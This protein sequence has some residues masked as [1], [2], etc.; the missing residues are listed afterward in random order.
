MKTPVFY[1]KLKNMETYNPQEIEPKWQ[2]YWEENGF[3]KAEDFS[4]PR[5]Q[6]GRKPK[7]YLLLEFP[8]PSGDGLHVG[9]CRPYCALDAIARQKRMAGANVLFPIGWDA[10][11]LPTENYAIKHGIHPSIATQKNIANFKRQL[12]NLGLSFDW[13]REINTTDP[14]YYKWTQWIFLKLLEKDLAYQAEIPIN[15]CPACKIGLANEEAVGGACER[16]G[17]VVERKVQKQWMLKIT[18][19]ADRLI[20]DLEGLDFPERVKSQQINW[21]GKSFG[22]EIQFPINNLSISVFTT[23][24]DT[25]FGVT[26]MVLAPEHPLVEK[27]VAPE[28]KESVKKYIEDAKRKSDFEREKLEKEKTGVFTGSFCRHPLTDEKIPIWIGDY[29]ISAYGGGAVMMVPAHDQRDFG[30]SKKYNL[31]LKIVIC[32]NYPEPVCPILDKAYEGEGHLVSSG[33]F[34]GLKSAEAIKKITKELEKKKLGKETIQYKLRDWVFSRQHYWGEP[35]PVVHCPKC[36]TVPV[37]EKDLPVELPYIEKYQPSHTGESPLSAIT[38]WVNVKCPTC[39]G[40]AKRETDTMP[41]WAGSNWYF[42][43]YCDSNNDKA[44]AD[45]KK[46]K[47]WLPVDWY[48]GGMEHTT[49][50]LLYSRFI[51]KFLFDI[52]VAP[53]KEPYQKRTSHG[54]VL[55]GDGRKMSKSFGNVVN[56]D[57]I[58]QKYG[59]D[60]LRVYEMFMGPFDQAISWNEDGVKGVARFLEK[61]WKIS[62]TCAGNKQS[63]EDILRAIHKLNKKISEELGQMKFNTIIAGFM[64]FVNLAQEKPT[65]VGSD[66]IERMLILL[67]PFAPHMAED[68]WSRLGHKNSI[69]QEKWPEYSEEII[70]KDTTILVIQINGKTRDTIEVKTGISE[71]EARELTLS[72]KKVKTYIL[73]K[74][75]KKVIFVPGKLINIVV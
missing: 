20:D 40:P 74:E 67:S 56:P 2:K 60:T 18:A 58:V 59:A 47:Y 37:S 35:I 14:K 11:G 22:T 32:P 7:Q 61:A 50:H 54:V 8:Y 75:I 24:A 29:V 28:N 72:Q 17:A 66:A 31:P 26:A 30:F 27:I 1:V 44:L 39:G 48:N 71:K 36:G 55:A 12:K 64:E 21:I 13:S 73:D 42:M 49:L 19:Y 16:C 25:L 52:K 15:W 53:Q 62:L 68:L 45:P 63:N 43:R 9:H 51:Y 3:Y 23:R 10:F 41:N 33:K 6:A 65:E 69:F 34:N 70:K 57:D 46:L 5:R 38:D 4:L